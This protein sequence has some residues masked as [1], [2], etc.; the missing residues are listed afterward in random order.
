[1]YSDS[2]L[3]STISNKLYRL[4]DYINKHE[5]VEWVTFEQMSDYFKRKNTPEAGAVMPATQS[6]VEEMLKKHKAK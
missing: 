2:I 3:I 1:M 6:E 5:G 4:I